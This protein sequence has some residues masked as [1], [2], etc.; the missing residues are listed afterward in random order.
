MYLETTIII[1]KHEC[2]IA[3]F[4]HYTSHK[5]AGMEKEIFKNLCHKKLFTPERK[6]VFQES[7]ATV[8]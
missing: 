5:G 2:E 1:L 4:V 6:S 8:K 7:R 3:V